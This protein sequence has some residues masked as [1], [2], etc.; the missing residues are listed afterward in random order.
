MWEGVV[1]RELYL[2][3]LNAT[4]HLRYRPD[5]GRHHMHLLLHLTDILQR[6]A[7]LAAAGW[8]TVCQDFA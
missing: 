1:G 6:Y 7:R 8:Q 4:R 2:L 3:C 5:A